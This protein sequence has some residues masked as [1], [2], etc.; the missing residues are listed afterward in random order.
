M[1][2]ETYNQLY[3]F[4]NTL[5]YPPDTTP[6]QQLEIRKQSFKYFIKNQQLYQRNQKQ[7]LQPLLVIKTTEVETLIHNIHNEPLGGHL[8]RDITYNKIASKYYWPNMYRIINNWIK[9]CDIYQR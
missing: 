8:G 7:L 1:D 6:A 5:N 9:T 2:L 4:L 3:N